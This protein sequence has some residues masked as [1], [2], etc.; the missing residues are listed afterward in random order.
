[1]TNPVTIEDGGRI[2]DDTC[3]KAQEKATKW[4][5]SSD[6]PRLRMIFHTQL[7]NALLSVIMGLKW[8]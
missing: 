1:M 2:W 6:F 7:F 3:L 5:L 4:T 8:H